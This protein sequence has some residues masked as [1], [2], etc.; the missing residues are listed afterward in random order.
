MKISH[1]FH[2]YWV[3][4]LVA[5]V[6]FGNIS[7]VFFFFSSKEKISKDFE[8]VHALEVLIL[9]N[10]QL[11]S[12][13][14]YYEIFNSAF[15]ESGESEFFDESQQTV[16]EIHQTLEFLGLKYQS[17]SDPYLKAVGG[18]LEM[19]NDIFSEMKAVLLERGFKDWG[20]VGRMRD[21]AHQLE[22]VEYFDKAKLLMLRRHE[23]DFIIRNDP[24]YVKLFQEKLKR[25]VSEIQTE[26]NWSQEQKTYTTQILKN[27]GRAFFDLVS[28]DRK[29]GI[30][31]PNLEQG[32]MWE[33]SIVNEDL[34]NQYRE[35][36]SESQSRKRLL[37]SRLVVIF[38]SL[39]ILLFAIASYVLFYTQRNINSPVSRLNSYLNTL[40]D[41][42]FQTPKN[43]EIPSQNK[44]IQNLIGNVAILKLE[45]QQT[46]RA[47][48]SEKE[49]AEEADRLKTAF[50]AN[51][52]HDIRTP[53]NAIIGFSNILSERKCSREEEDEYL[54]YIRNCGGELLNLIDDI[55]D[56][57]KIESDSLKIKESP[58]DIHETLKEL[59]EGIRQRRDVERPRLTIRSNFEN[60]AQP[61][62]I[63]TDKN[64]FRQIVNNLL[65]NAF[66][67]TNSGYIE[68][69]YS[70]D[71][72]SDNLVFYVEDTG[73][74]IPEDKQTVIF[75]RFGQAD[76]SHATHHGG[77]G[78]GL[79][80]S[81]K[82]V[83]ILGGKLWLKSVPGEGSTFYFTL[84]LKLVAMDQT[85]P[86]LENPDI[87]N[88]QN[89]SLMIAEDS[90]LNFILLKRLLEP[91]KIRI[92]RAH[93]G[94]E[95]LHKL[96]ES[97]TQY[98]LI[99]MDLKM[100]V[101]DGFEATKLVKR[102]YPN[103]PVI[104]QTASGMTEE[105]HQCLRVGC[106]KCISKPYNKTELYSAIRN[107]LGT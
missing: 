4:P 63:E 20:V 11:Q 10:E 48:Q 51:M 78:L 17:L 55:I 22:N 72:T 106:D 88:W 90:D 71:R 41:S 80:I 86:A 98:D 103:L 35:L 54:Q 75:E 99:L 69:G 1:K 29:L 23:K 36:Y 27:Y 19:S 93:D 37:V 52:S 18:S 9:E 59:Y 6:V 26:Q 3:V 68:L 60:S 89:V 100:P 47:L 28:V 65:S 92:A 45:I 97:E 76:S 87:P 84:P 2:I 57:A 30:K 85:E 64:R 42:K 82:L 105:L 56:V 66:K 62:I 94:R 107:S 91:T 49:K 25:Y 58:C 102:E 70:I 12:Q 53:M 15:F 43:P 14:F 79:A 32:L 61:L 44:L 101:M 33:L 81:K 16:K 77:T 21:S 74:G 67:F 13:F 24:N 7:L 38:M 8:K 95:L 39:I 83:E 96:S 104:A 31:D 40:V 5:I 73:I 34:M 46:F 50:L